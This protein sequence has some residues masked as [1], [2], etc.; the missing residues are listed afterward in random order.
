M[1]SIINAVWIGVYLGVISYTA[2]VTMLTLAATFTTIGY[3]IVRIVVS[4]DRKVF[5]QPNQP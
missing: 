2:L 5:N 3:A 4:I 1:K